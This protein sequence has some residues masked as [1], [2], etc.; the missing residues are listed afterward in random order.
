[1]AAKR[2]RKKSAKQVYEKWRIDNDSYE[3][4]DISYK[5]I[6]KSIRDGA[7]GKKLTGIWREVVASEAGVG[8]PMKCVRSE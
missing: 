5:N 7:A 6:I 8:V 4:A 1:M 2:Q 3:A